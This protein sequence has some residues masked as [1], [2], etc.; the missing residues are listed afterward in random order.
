MK[1]A[2]AG[3]RRVWRHRWLRHLLV[4]AVLLG[5]LVVLARPL[6]IT[7]VP[8][9]GDRLVVIGVVERGAPS[10]VDS[11]LLDERAD[12]A[13]YGVV[14]THRDIG[15]C[16]SATWLSLGSGR[17]AHTGEECDLRLV[18]APATRLGQE[19]GASVSNWGRLQEMNASY[20]VDLGHRDA[21]LADATDPGSDRCITAVGP[22]AALAAADREGRVE[23]YTDMS[24][25]Q[26]RGYPTACR[27]TLVDATTTSEEMITRLVDERGATVL[28]LGLGTSGPLEH[29]ALG[30]APADKVSLS[31]VQLAYR[32]DPAGSSLPGALS[33]QTTREAGVITLS[34]A[35]AMVVDVLRD[36]EDPAPRG[37]LPGAPLGVVPG[38]V[39]ADR[40]ADLVA[41]V[42]VLQHR[43]PI[44][45]AFGAGLVALLAT[46]ALMV[47][48]R[49]WGP[50]PWVGAALTTWPIA[51]LS[52]GMWPWYAVGMPILAGI[53]HVYGAWL[54]ATVLARGLTTERRPAGIAGASLTLALTAASAALGDA[55]QWGTLLD[56]TTALGP[57]WVGIG[58]GAAA[59]C[60]GAAL[61][62]AAWWADRLPRRES[63][64]A[65][66][67]LVVLVGIVLLPNISFTVALLCGGA[68]LTFADTARSWVRAAIP[69]ADP[70]FSGNAVA[71]LVAA[72]V[73][74]AL[75]L[76][77][78]GTILL[79]LAPETPLFGGILMGWLGCV[80]LALWLQ[81]RAGPWFAARDAG[82]LPD[83]ATL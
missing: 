37:E 51:L 53:G 38:P 79:H 19:G 33:S 36:D 83:P 18:L 42:D 63:V 28:V 59:A 55:W 41:T 26:A 67:A 10:V 14:T 34:D 12:S 40:A 39:S 35:S 52:A 17:R 56:S 45:L 15:E 43:R 9:A 69:W 49:R 62:I 80:T 66:V 78:S 64:V 44:L 77:D 27:V 25:W 57:D 48:R 1:A 23:R 8:V 68:V 13:A 20:G 11:R 82:A 22:G 54:L 29:D 31:S 46:A 3:W 58:P 72:L 75:L 5:V 74:T 6:G 61:T 47:T 2:S 16:I 70:L 50:A 60:V 76:V 81:L 32:I 73:G 21:R 4:L 30:V 24:V 71:T 7:P 65:I